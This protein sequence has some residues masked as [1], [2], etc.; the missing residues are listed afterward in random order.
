M[1]KGR[2]PALCYKFFLRKYLVEVYLERPPDLGIDQDL[3]EGRDS[4]QEAVVSSVLPIHAYDLIDRPVLFCTRVSPGRRN[5]HILYHPDSISFGKHIN[6][7]VPDILLFLQLI[8]NILL[9]DP[10][11][12]LMCYRNREHAY[13]PVLS[14]YCPALL[15]KPN[16]PVKSLKAV[17]NLIVPGGHSDR[18]RMVIPIDLIFLHHLFQHLLQGK[19]NRQALDA[20]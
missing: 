13:D 2:G 5:D 3:P 12:S 14:A 19:A 8:L 17:Q 11:K 15:F 4:L 20:L 9:Y 18:N 10:L 16:G 1:F 6:F 7:Q